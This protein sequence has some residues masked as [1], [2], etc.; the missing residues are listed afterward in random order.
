MSGQTMLSVQST[1][2]MSVRLTLTVCSDSSPGATS[3]SL[4]SAY[5]VST[6][7]PPTVTVISSPSVGPGG[8][9]S[10][11]PE[12]AEFMAALNDADRRWS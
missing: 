9:V 6:A 7:R 11:L 5:P 8:R 4:V 3:W 12:L 1:S 10:K 2:K